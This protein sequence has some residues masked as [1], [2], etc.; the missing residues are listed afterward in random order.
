MGWYCSICKVNDNK[1]HTHP[2]RR[3]EDVELPEEKS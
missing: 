3:V 2:P 1:I